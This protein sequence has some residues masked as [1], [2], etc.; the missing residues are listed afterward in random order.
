M[1]HNSQK[2]N[3]KVTLSAL[4][5][6]GIVLGLII[7][8]GGTFNT[9]EASDHT[10]HH[11]TITTKELATGDL[12]YQMVSHI[13]EDPITVMTDVTEQRY[14]PNPIP[15]IPGPTLIMT[16]GDEMEITLI[17]EI[18]R[19][20]VSMH[21]HGVYYPIES[22]GTLK[23]TNNVVDSCAT[24]GQ[25]FVYNWSAADSG[26]VGTWPWHDHTFENFNGAEDRGL[27]AALIVNPADG[28]VPAFIAGQQV[29]VNVQDIEKEFVFYMTQI[30]GN[31]PFFAAEEIDNGNGGL[32]TP[33]G[34][35]PFF[36]AILGDNVRIHVIGMGNFFHTYHLHATRWLEP[37]TTDVIDTKNIGPLTRHA[38][39]IEAGQGVGSGDWMYHCHVFR[40]MEQGMT[41]MFRVLTSESTI[42]ADAPGNIVVN[43]GEKLVIKNG[44]TISQRIDVNG[45]T[46]IIKEGSHVNGRIIATEGSVVLIQDSSTA[47]PVIGI[48]TADFRVERSNIGW[49]LSIQNSMVVRVSDSTI[50]NNLFIEGTSGAPQN[51]FTLDNVV[52]GSSNLCP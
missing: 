5:S 49:D 12:A 3:W 47:G 46:L 13:I 11:V 29:M 17:N 8:L 27:Y 1:L 35:N 22:D 2:F 51:C 14:G 52:G 45:G 44:A 43:A 42:T 38:F 4:A 16:Q 31:K 25:P 41:G 9:A 48:D 19:D 36:D 15:Q 24:V 40:H 33:L 26:T 6:I 30:L 28:Q 18:G 21:V 39:V 20:C 37:G 32:Q 10:I 23:I 50:T 34:F 7:A